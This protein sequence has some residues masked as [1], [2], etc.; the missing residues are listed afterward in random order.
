[1]TGLS[2]S[3]KEAAEISGIGSGTLYELVAAGEVPHVKVG[4]KILIDKAAF[5]QWFT[6]QAQARAVLA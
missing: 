4:R 5:E 3:V 1:M 2:L 6:E